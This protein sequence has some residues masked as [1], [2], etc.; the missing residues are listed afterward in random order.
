MQRVS[1]GDGGGIDVLH[2]IDDDVPA[3]GPG[4][5]LIKVHAA[6]VNRPDVMQRSGTYPPPPGASPY[7]GLEVAGVVESLGEGVTTWV[8]GDRVCALTAGGGYSEY[9]VADA[10]HCLP[11]PTTLSLAQAA[12]LPETYFTVWANLFDPLRVGEGKRLL[13]HGGSS[14]IGLTA[15]QLARE[16]G[17]LVF[18]T[19]GSDEK[20]RAC[21]D[22]G[23]HR[24][25]NYRKENFSAVIADETAGRGIDVVLDMVGA[26]YVERNIQSLAIDGCL[27]Q[28]GTLEGSRFEFDVSPIIMRR[29]TITGSALRPR[30]IAQKASIAKGLHDRFWPVLNE[31][32]CLPVVNAIFPMN[33]VRE[34]HELMES[35]RHIGKIVLQVDTR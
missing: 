19:V 17:A 29:L 27:V 20:A 21:Q 33:R 12:A 16:A 26:T 11:V 31:R 5:V 2:L 1:H 34:A 23:A 18:T 10:S 15:I 7:L 4:Q 13:V 32:R 30:S 8:P 6:G 25:I 22:A 28:I 24:A 3:P 9:C 14:G 35:N